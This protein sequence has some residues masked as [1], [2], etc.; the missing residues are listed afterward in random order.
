MKKNILI[1]AASTFIWTVF[2]GI[3][4]NSSLLAQE[5]YEGYEGYEGPDIQLEEIFVLGRIE[6]AAQSL[7]IERIESNRVLDVLGAE[8]IERIGDATVAAALKRVPGVTLV[9]GQYI[10]VRGLG[11][12][13]S[14]SVLNGATVPSP[15]LTRNVLPLDI[16]PSSILES[17][18]VQKSYTADKPAAFGGGNIDIRTKGIPDDFIFSLSLGTG[19]DSD[20]SNSLDY[21]G[22]DNDFLGDDDG[23]RALSPVIENA[24][25]SFHTSLQAPEG[26]LS[27]L[28]IQ[29]TAARN[30]SPIS[31][32]EAEA[33]NANF[34]TLINR[35]LDISEE[36][37]AL[38]DI[39]IG[40]SLGNSYFLTDDIEFGFLTSLNY[41]NSS[42]SDERITR[43][44]TD[45]E[46]EFT[47]EFRTTE[48]TNITAVANFGVS[49]LNDHKISSK[50]IFLRNTDD[51]VSITDIFNTSASFSSGSGGRDF[52]YRFEQRELEVIQFEG[53][54]RLGYDTRDLLGL[55]DSFLDD[56]EVSWFYSDSTATT[57]IPSETNIAAD[58]IRDVNTNEVTSVTLDQ[59]TRLVDVRYTELEDKVESSG[60]TISLPIYTRD[61]DIELSAGGQLDT[62]AR[63]YE[64][65]DLSLGSASSAADSTLGG[66]ISD[67][68]SDENL[69]NPD[70]EYEAFFQSGL[71]RS[72]IA[73]STIESFF[74]QADISWQDSWQLVAGVRFEDYKQFTSPFQ[75][76]RINGSRLRADLTTIT[77]SGF[78]E[79]I[80]AQDDFY[81]SV[82][83]TYRAQDFWAED[84]NLRFAVSETVVRPDLREVSDASYLDPLTDI[85]VNGNPNVVPSDILNFDLRAEWFFSSGDTLSLSYFLKDIDNPIEYF[86]GLGSEDSLTASIENAATGESSGVEI[87]FSKYLDFL[88]DFASQFFITGNITLADSEIDVGDDLLIPVTNRTRPL[89]GASDYVYNFV[90][91]Y[92]AFDGR[93]AATLGYNVSGERVFLAGTSSQEDVFE[94]P[95]NALD[96]SYSYFPNDKFTFGLKVRNLLGED[97]EIDQGGVTV[98]EQTVGSSYS[99]D[100]KYAF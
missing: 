86:Q 52:D 68:L 55:G 21:A 90:L 22:G 23:T 5:I 46:E 79:G 72:Y 17:I 10:Y 100:M 53:T 26:D 35:D 9:D 99:L 57:Y 39:S 63:I 34:A 50:N 66:S 43:V 20:S 94:Q 78:P 93:H 80:F 37:S 81:P 74:G 42:R 1:S 88:G 51:E 73:A 61:W 70:F 96:L 77:D 89:T 27:A 15:D 64:Q 69:T 62:K 48:N 60:F 4:S 36:D 83:L 13:Y 97:I 65:L 58:I 28:A 49:W 75:P 31:R 6:S 91:N 38:Q 40:A 33:I 82:S 19:L 84:F 54:H 3:T 95:F 14:N 30:G 7:V 16:F 76:F 2:F 12:R 18:A 11:E 85:V 92:D 71:S 67:A 98:Y 47:D 32:E 44:V 45:P 59:S 87:E 24:L 8:Q 56:L 41:S 25:N 29:N